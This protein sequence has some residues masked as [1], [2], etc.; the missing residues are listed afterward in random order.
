M[1]IYLG[2]KKDTISQGNGLGY[3]TVIT[4]ITALDKE[5]IVRYKHHYSEIIEAEVFLD[6]TDSRRGDEQPRS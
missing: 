2:I 6:E 5:D 1:K 3:E 4:D